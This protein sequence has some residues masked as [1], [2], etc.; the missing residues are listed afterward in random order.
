VK[1]PNGN[2]ISDIPYRIKSSAGEVFS[3]T[4]KDGLSE[5]VSTESSE[6]IEFTIDWFKVVPGT[7][8]K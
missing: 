3:S 4:L 6:N 2:P 7:N 8:M 1:D 5:R